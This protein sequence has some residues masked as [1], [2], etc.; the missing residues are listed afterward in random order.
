M[1]DR[2]AYPFG[3]Q[4]CRQTGIALLLCLLFLTALVLT[5]LNASADAIMQNQLAANQQAREQAEQAAAEALTWAESWL[6]TLDLEA[7]ATQIETTQ[8][9]FLLVNVNK[10]TPIEQR[11]AKWWLENGYPIGADPA[12]NAKPSA[13][14]HFEPGQSLWLVEP[15][16][17][18]AASNDGTTGV[19][20]WY[21]IVARGSNKTGLVSV[22]ESIMVRSWPTEKQ[23]SIFNT[24]AS[25]WCEFDFSNCGRKTWRKLR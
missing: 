9:E 16:H 6:Q 8:A 13:V 17:W 10:D 19:R 23:A 2:T 11:T 7:P 24:N 5:V 15:L 3:R 25:D 12:D 18:Q 14:T 22:T 1:T 20:A 4:L 21:R